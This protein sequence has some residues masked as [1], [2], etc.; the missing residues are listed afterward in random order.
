MSDR[1]ESSLELGLFEWPQQMPSPRPR[2]R[3]RWCCLRLELDQNRLTVCERPLTISKQLRGLEARNGFSVVV[4]MDELQKLFQD[5]IKAENLVRHLLRVLPP[6]DVPM[7]E[8]SN[9]STQFQ[10]RDSARDGTDGVHDEPY[11]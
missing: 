7:A 4:A 9:G 5:C 1:L 8:R 6:A 10:E 2:I 3:A 11:R